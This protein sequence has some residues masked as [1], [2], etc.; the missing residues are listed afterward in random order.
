M[1]RS[2]LGAAELDGRHGRCERVLDLVLVLS[3]VL[4]RIRIGWRWIVVGILAR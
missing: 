3:L 4:D 1:R 2:R